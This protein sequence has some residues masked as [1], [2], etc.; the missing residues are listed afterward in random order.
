MNFL[1][2][3]RAQEKRC[4]SGITIGRGFNL[5]SSRGQNGRAQPSAFSKRPVAPEDVV[6]AGR[7]Q[8]GLEATEER[9]QVAEKISSADFA[10]HFH[11]IKP[12]SIPCI[13]FEQLRLLCPN[14]LDMPTIL[15]A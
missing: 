5:A 4:W 7:L 6:P 8:L 14:T 1:Q 12:E 9:D 11:L 15:S 2:K 10:A 13:Y 3:K